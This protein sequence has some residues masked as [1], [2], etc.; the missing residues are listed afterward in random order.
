M[1]FE[2]INPAAKLVIVGISPGLDQMKIAYNTVRRCLA[3]GMSYEE[4]AKQA[5][6]EAAFGGKLRKN[7]NAI[8]DHFHVPTWLGVAKSDDLFESRQDL[9]YSTSVVPHAAF[10]FDDKKGE[11]NGL[12][13]EF[14]TNVLEVPA[15][16]DC[17]MNSFVKRLSEIQPGAKFLALGPFVKDALEWCVENEYLDR[18]RILGTIAHPSGRSGSQVPTFIGIRKVDSLK[19]LDPVRRR[20]TKFRGYYDGMAREMSKLLG[21]P[22]PTSAVTYASK[23]A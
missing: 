18:S 7:L 2:H 16:R 17:F 3:Q 14:E 13:D 8:L 21:R 15:F 10:I 19:P 6:H 5:K 4:A 22:L 9:I 23:A 12:S 11:W 20:I 1:P